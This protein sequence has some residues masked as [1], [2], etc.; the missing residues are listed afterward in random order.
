[1]GFE[2]AFQLQLVGAGLNCPDMIAHRGGAGN[3]NKNHDCG[4]EGSRTKYYSK[5]FT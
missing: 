2:I 1:L 3:G 4:N 5:F